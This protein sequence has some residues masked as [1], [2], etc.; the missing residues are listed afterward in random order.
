MVNATSAFGAGSNST[1]ASSATINSALN[2][3]CGAAAACPEDT[4]RSKLTA[5]YAAC[6]PELTTTPNKDVI[7]AYDVLYALYPL[8]QSVCSKGDDGRYC[9]VTLGSTSG[10][11]SSGSAS[12]SGKV[13]LAQD[14]SSSP[15]LKQIQ[16]QLWTPVASDKSV[17][18][19][20]EQAFYPNTTT[21]N[22]ANILFLL[23]QPTLSAAALCVPCTRLVVSAYIA[24]QTAIPY[25]PGISNSPLMSGETA[26]YAA[27]QSTCGASFLSN[28]V[29]AA[30]G[31]SG[32]IVSS[33][34]TDVLVNFKTLGAAALVGFFATL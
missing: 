30:G 13:N 2:T 7:R 19:R 20:D 8:T 29:Q 1:K 22:D 26:L 27:V 24:F 9:V 4:L 3:L 18:R 6:E 33:G 12:P 11:S 31:I 5:F 25:A 15:D 34:A 10:S 17:T 14:K 28:S 16:E 21:F 32:G 23:L